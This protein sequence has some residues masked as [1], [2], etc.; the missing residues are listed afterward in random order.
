VISVEQRLK[1]LKLTL[2]TVSAPVANYVP[3]VVSGSLVYISGQISRD[4]Q[5]NPSFLGKLGENISLEEG[6]EAAKS[7]ALQIISVLKEACSGDLERVVRCVKLG[8]F[9]NSTSDFKSQP[10]VV[11]GA[12][13]TMVAVFADKGKHA[14]A[15]VGVESLPAGV[16]VEVEAIFEIRVD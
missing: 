14:R 13:D 7:C 16:S 10:I 1:D 5:G 9:V 3:Y 4:S 11:N 12:S 2:P 8:G 15:A 6:I